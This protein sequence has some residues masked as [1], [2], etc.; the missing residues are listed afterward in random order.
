MPRIADWHTSLTA[1]GRSKQGRCQAEI[2]PTLTRLNWCACQRGKREVR[3]TLRFF[4]VR[5]V[6][7]AMMNCGKGYWVADHEAVD[8][9]ECCGS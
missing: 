3:F 6:G 7:L 4:R 2:E 8:T 5:A 9:G 1:A